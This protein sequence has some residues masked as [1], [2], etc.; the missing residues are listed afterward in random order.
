LFLC[1][2]LTGF[3]RNIN[4]QFAKVEALYVPPQSPA[5]QGYATA[6]PTLQ[7]Q[8]QYQ[9]QQQQA[10]APA[11]PQKQLLQKVPIQA[12]LKTGGSAAVP[13]WSS[14]AITAVRTDLATAAAATASASD[15]ISSSSSGSTVI[16]GVVKKGSSSVKGTSSNSSVNN[17][18]NKGS[19]GSINATIDGDVDDFVEP[20]SPAEELMVSTHLTLYTITI[21]HGSTSLKRAMCSAYCVHTVSNAPFLVYSEH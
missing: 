14:A 18:A 5:S 17:K 7:Q 15:A 21:L 8:L 19:S 4:V 2:V 13:T 3:T 6:F 12:P 16:K 11:P 1:Y 20:L 10:A 9:S